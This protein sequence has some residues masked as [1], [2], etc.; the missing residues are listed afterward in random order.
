LHN[1]PIGCSASGAYAPKG[2]GEEEEVFAQLSGRLKNFWDGRLRQLVMNHLCLQHTVT[3]RFQ[4]YPDIQPE[5]KKKINFLCYY[6]G[7]YV[8]QNK[9]TWSH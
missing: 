8:F 4:S 1:K 6:K 2:G 7:N 9:L 3:E 5:K